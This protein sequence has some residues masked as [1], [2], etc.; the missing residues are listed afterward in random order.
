M[1]EH[2]LYQQRLQRQQLGS[3][4]QLLLRL[5]GTSDLLRSF[6]SCEA[7]PPQVSGAP[8][9]M[10]SSQLVGQPG[11]FCRQVLHAE[12]CL[13]AHG[14]DQQPLPPLTRAA[15]LFSRCSLFEHCLNT[16]CAEMLNCAGWAESV[17]GQRRESAVADASNAD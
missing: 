6:A 3:G 14:Y 5:Q 4:C 2:L 13:L 1:C 15:C 8:T 11:K 10:E 12:H 17:C 16:I 7:V 9:R